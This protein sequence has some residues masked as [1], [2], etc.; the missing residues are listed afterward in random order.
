[1]IT[2]LLG[3]ASSAAW[4]VSD[5]VAGLTSRRAPLL[6]VLVFSQAIGVL[7][8]LGI[9]AV[10]AEPSLSTADI[11]WVVLSAILGATGLGCLYRGLAIGRMGVVAPVTGVIVAVVPVTVGIALDG[12][13]APAVVAGI[14]L[15]LASVVIVARVPGEIGGP[16][17][18]LLWGVGAGTTLGVFTVTISRVSAGLVFGP[19][20]LMRS[21]ETLAFLA[22]IVLGRRAWRV[23]RTFWPALVVV[24]A[25]DM[26][27]TAAYIAATQ[28]GPLAIAAVVSAL[29]PVFTVLLA[30][31]VLRERVTRIHALGIA[32]AAVAIVLITGGSAG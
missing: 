3:L 16:A 10:R 14:A 12:I 17:S 18:G 8:A 30:A 24:G 23:P 20:V 19:L 4:G 21:V 31:V 5:F 29:Y 27:A 32:G 11:E 22:V 13:P 28:A 7:I 9:A 26:G 25:M 15:A 2:V 6:G 1:M